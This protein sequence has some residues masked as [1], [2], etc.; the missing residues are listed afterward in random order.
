MPAKISRTSAT[1]ASL[2]KWRAVRLKPILTRGRS[3]STGAELVAQPRRISA[4]VMSRIRPDDS[5]SGMNAAGGT[6][7]PSALRQRIS[8]SAPTI[9]PLRR[10]TIGW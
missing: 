5:A 3:P 10:S 4:R 7:L 8:T 6:T 9:A 2:A 1:I